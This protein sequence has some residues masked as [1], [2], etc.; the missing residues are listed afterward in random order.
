MTYDVYEKNFRLKASLAGYSEEEIL[1][2][3]KYAKPLLDKSLPVIYNTSNL[4][5]LVGYNKNYMKRAVH[6]PDFFYRIFNI[7]KKNGKLREIK[8]PLP[9]LKEIQVWIL[10]NI[11]YNV[12][13]SKFAKAYVPKRNMLDNVRYHR[14]KDLV[15]SLDIENFF[16]SIKESSI[17]RIFEFMGYS[18]NISNLLSKL[19]CYEN[20]LPQGAPTSAYLSNI[21]LIEF[22]NLVADLCTKIE[23]RYTRYADDLFFSGEFDEDKIIELVAEELNKLNLKLNKEK[24]KVMRQSDRQI[25]T[26]IVVNK[27]IQLSNEN[28]KE[29]R[30]EIFYIKKF[31]L[32]SHLAKTKNNRANYIFHLLR[33]INYAIYINPKDKKMLE[34]KSYINDAYMKGPESANN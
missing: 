27:T 11:L 7:K 12:P 4:A 18:S 21:Y 25:I 16:P 14:G 26:G 34:Y 10:R 5:A 8:E 30:Q 15:L 9:S 29:I 2:C 22:D 23:V 19:C 20:I 3:L 24:I 31:G 13:V 6:H 32:E 1:K 17:Q 33:K 28:R